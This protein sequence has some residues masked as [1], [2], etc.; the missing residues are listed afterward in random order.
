MKN[1]EIFTTF[2]ACV[3]FL[4]ACSS[5]PV[6]NERSW[7]HQPTRTVD[8]GYIIYVGTGESNDSTRAIFEAEGMAIQDLASE[9]SFV[10]KGARIEDRYS[11]KNNYTFKGYAKIAIEF[12]DCDIAK[13]TVDPAKLRAMASLPFT[14]QLKKYQDQVE[15]A[16][17]ADA[18]VPL[19]VPD[20][21]AHESYV[22]DDSH[23]F[24][25]RQY[26]AYQKQTVILSPT[27][28]YAPY[29]PETKAYARNVLATTDQIQSYETKNPQIKTTPATW[30]SE[31]NMAL[32]KQ[33]KLFERHNFSHSESSNPLKPIKSPY[34]P[35]S[36]KA[37]MLP[38]NKQMKKQ[39]KK[40]KKN[41]Y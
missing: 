33:P 13:K 30:S 21:P 35:K 38:S 9:C 16:Q 2:I 32:Q 6:A 8:N 31:K 20:A 14:D 25:V 17:V 22:H 7:I 3:S 24:V 19:D 11:E 10:P 15:T 40:T 39:Q 23:F 37:Q 12:Q 34:R 41:D 27:T 28:A 1:A 26:V 36:S 5:D 29:S 18:G 4:T